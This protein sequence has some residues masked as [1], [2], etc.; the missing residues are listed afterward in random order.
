MDTDKK[1]ENIG[2]YGI[3]MYNL[4]KTNHWEPRGNALIFWAFKL[5]ADLN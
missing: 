4:S 1:E 5:H 3:L 2:I